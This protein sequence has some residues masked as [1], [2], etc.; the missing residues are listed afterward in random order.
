M[1][2]KD[3]A[4]LERAFDHEIRAALTGTPHVMQT[5]SN[6]RADALVID[7]LLTKCV[8]VWR[9]VRITGYVLTHAGRYAYCAKCP[10]EPTTEDCA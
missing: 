2:K 5:K 7:G 4:L 6:A 9:G 10:D 8:E 1:N 3:L